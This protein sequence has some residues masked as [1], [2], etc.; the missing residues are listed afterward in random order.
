[1]GKDAILIILLTIQII[2]TTQLLIIRPF[3]ELEN[4]IVEIINE[5]FYCAFVGLMLYLDG[6][7]MWTSEMIHL[8]IGLI[9]LN[10]LVIT[11]IMLGN[12]LLVTLVF[13]FLSLIKCWIKRRTKNRNKKIITE[14]MSKSTEKNVSTIIICALIYRSRK[15]RKSLRKTTL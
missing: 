6:E 5:M 1:L 10:S 14:K 9:T 12:L 8:F 13:F 7:E 11:A 3:S 4:N 2:Y 15:A